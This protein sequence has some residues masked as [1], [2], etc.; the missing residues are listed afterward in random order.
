[1]KKLLTG[2][3]VIGSLSSFS[4]T[5]FS[6]TSFSS[7]SIETLS[8]GNSNSFLGAGKLSLS[9]RHDIS[10]KVKAKGS[11]RNQGD[12]YSA[13]GSG[14]IGIKAV[15]ANYTNN[16]SGVLDFDIGASYSFLDPESSSDSTDQV[17][18]E[19][20]ISR[21]LSDKVTG[22]AGLNISK[23]IR[24]DFADYTTAGAGF[25]L[26]F[27]VSLTNELLLDLRYWETNN[28]YEISEDGF[29]EKIDFNMSSTSVGVSYIF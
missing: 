11:R 10:P 2:L 29:D 18:L 9:Y 25:Q 4:S 1:M 16:L 20:N 7:T 13:N 26:G 14:E 23:F 22:F 17:R 12:V 15:A 3:M 6:S 24:S 19:G 8:S 27:K 28:S 21:R 5:S